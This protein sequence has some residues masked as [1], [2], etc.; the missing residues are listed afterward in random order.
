VVRLVLDTVNRLNVG[1]TVTLSSPVLPFELRLHLRFKEDSR[2][3][4]DTDIEGIPRSFVLSVFAV[5]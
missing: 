4:L 3:I 2:L 5:R 1:E